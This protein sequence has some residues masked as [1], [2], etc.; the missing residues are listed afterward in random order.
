MDLYAL[1]NFDVSYLS[2]LNYLEIRNLCKTNKQ[3]FTICN[4]NTILRSLIYK[5]NPK[6]IISP[7][8]NIAGAL[9]D[10]H[11]QIE[12]LFNDNFDINGLPDYIIPD[13]FKFRHVK[14]LMKFFVHDLS[15]Y[16]DGNVDNR[17]GKI[18]FPKFIK[19]NRLLVGIPFSSEYAESTYD[20]ETSRAWRDIPNTIFLSDII[21][22]IKPSIENLITFDDEFYGIDYYDISTI[23]S[24]LFLIY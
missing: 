5:R 23:L 21:N 1:N 11:N 22:Y 20:D 2:K 8:Y 6:I 12:D 13:K 19:L 7:N 9:K 17:N 24:D 16:L 18:E 3:Y 4:D 10:F 15:S 14:N